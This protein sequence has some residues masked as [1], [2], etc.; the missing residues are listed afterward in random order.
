MKQRKHIDLDERQRRQFTYLTLLVAAAFFAVIG[1]VGWWLAIAIAVG[2]AI[3]E[4]FYLFAKRK[5]GRED[6]GPE[7]EKPEELP[8]ETEESDRTE[9][10]GESDEEDGKGPEA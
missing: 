9:G 2:V 6:K 7:S 10:S 8:Q 3:D 5:A 4:V 1:Q